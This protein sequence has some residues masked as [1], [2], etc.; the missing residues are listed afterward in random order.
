MEYL[1][2][3]NLMRYFFTYYI[4]LNGKKVVISHNIFN[5][6][7]IKDI[8]LGSIRKKLGT[9]IPDDS[10]FLRGGKI[11]TKENEDTIILDKYNNTYGIFLYSPS[12][13]ND[14]FLIKENPFKSFKLL[15]K[16]KSFDIYEYPQKKD[17][18]NYY[19][20]IIFGMENKFFVDGFLNF[21]FDIQYED[22]YRLKLEFLENQKDNVINTFYIQSKKGNFKLICINFKDFYSFYKDDVKQIID[23]FNKETQIDLCIINLRQDFLFFNE[24]D[25]KEELLENLEKINIT[26]EE[27][28]SGM[29]IIEPNLLYLYLKYIYSEN[30]FKF[31]NDNNNKIEKLNGELLK[32]TEDLFPSSIFCPFFIYES[33]VNNKQLGCLYNQIMEGYSKIYESIIKRENKKIDMSII[34][35]YLSFVLELITPLT[36]LK[37]EIEIQKEKFTNIQNKF[38]KMINYIDSL[39][40]N[41]YNEERKKIFDGK[42]KN[43]K[44][45]NNKMQ[46]YNS[47]INCFNRDIKIEK[48][49]ESLK[50]DSL[51][52]YEEVIIRVIILFLLKKNDSFNQID[53]DFDDDV[54]LIF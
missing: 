8:T 53:Y 16:K 48:F 30:K 37:D 39:K 12:L 26:K 25:I 22:I 41:K 9:I 44:K 3:C 2:F 14:W 23:M 31:E 6:E 52:N 42:C 54:C 7:I 18:S 4:Y 50:I 28:N 24:D 33:E 36:K 27:D 47:S 34:K 40:N 46:K 49:K 10:V 45:M 17:E 29:F 19:T 20:I 11:I 1:A 15:E 32:E 38:T 43:E 21:L 13:N 5:N 51:R 35:S